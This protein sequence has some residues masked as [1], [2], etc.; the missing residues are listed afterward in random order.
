MVAM[1][2][3][4]SDILQGMH[5]KEDNRM[6]LDIPPKSAVFGDNAFENHDLEDNAE[7]MGEIDWEIM[8][9][10]T[11]PVGIFT[12]SPVARTDF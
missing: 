5:H 10:K 12:K 1:Y 2:V 8:R 7:Q 4:F 11:P 9:K 6:Y 3:T